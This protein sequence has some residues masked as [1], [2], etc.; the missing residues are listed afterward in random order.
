MAEFHLSATTSGHLEELVTRGAVRSSV[1]FVRLAIAVGLAQDHRVALPSAHPFRDLAALDPQRTFTVIVA[2]RD[3]GCADDESVARALE[4]YA[5][6]GAREL[7]SRL[8]GGGLDY[9]G[10]YRELTT[11]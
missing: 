4:Q 3:L 1:D 5:E 7:L 10:L 8:D 9:Y 2:T 11:E 6:A